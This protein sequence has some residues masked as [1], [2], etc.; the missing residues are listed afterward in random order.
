MEEKD[1]FPK[2]K[3]IPKEFLPDSVIKSEVSL[4][5]GEI[6]KIGES[7]SDVFSPIYV[8]K[9]GEYQKQKLGSVTMM[10][11]QESELAL[12][13]ASEAFRKNIWKDK[14]L[15][16]R[17]SAVKIFLNELAKYKDKIV[18]L[19]MWETAKP[20]PEA[21]NEFDRTIDYIE[22]T[23]DEAIK[24]K[25]EIISQSSAGFVG[26]V[27]RTP[28]GIVITMGPS[29]YPMYETYSLALPALLCGNSVVLKVPRYGTLLHHH[30]LQPLRDS[31]PKGVI[32]VLRG[33]NEETVEPLM[34]TGSPDMLAYFGS[35]MFAEPLLFAHPKPNR[36]IK[37]LGL[38]AKNPAIV[39]DDEN[40]KET[41]REIIL[42]AL[43]FNGQRCAAI[44]IVFAHKSIHDK[45]VSELKLCIDKTIIGMPWDENVRITPIFDP[46]RVLYLHSLTDDAIH[47]GAELV[48]SGGGQ[49]I[50][51]IFTPAL[52]TNIKKNMQ[53]YNEEQFGPIIPVYEYE[54]INEIIDYVY[55][56]D[57]GQQISIFGHNDK[58]ITEL[59][60]HFKH[61]AGRININTKCQRG[62]DIFP[63]TGKKNSGQGA[64]SILDT[65]LEFSLPT[66]VAGKANDLTSSIIQ[67][68]L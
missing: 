63:F 37:L 66:V 40:I 38:E 8:F 48:N 5:N 47:K 61:Q 65:L 7:I 4:I 43:A 23:C 53:I 50:K 34:R 16:Y 64:L 13:S 21:E 12:F 27:L 1:I 32:N 33:K 68:V 35:S 6:A 3:D 49:V 2:Y 18:K 26:K 11:G 20:F 17:I 41:A 14:P 36:L 19:L 29:N 67:S 31:F 54:D 46:N 22:K 58:Y 56:S 44:K 45:L 42:G 39:L 25:D 15:A 55:D 30:I 10:N 28:I 57:F 51:S 24:Y 59:L 62:P 60:S 52:L 9:K